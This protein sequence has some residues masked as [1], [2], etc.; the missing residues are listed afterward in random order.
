MLPDNPATWTCPRTYV[1]IVIHENGSNS[2][3]FYQLTAYD[4]ILAAASNGSLACSLKQA[5]QK[6]RKGKHVMAALCASLS[7]R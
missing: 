6:G 3:C 4:F 1:Y 7:K 5:K 2:S